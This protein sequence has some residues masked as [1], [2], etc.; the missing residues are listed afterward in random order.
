VQTLDDEP[1]LDVYLRRL[2]ISEPASSDELGRIAMQ[3][4][5]GLSR[6]GP[7]EHVRGITG[8]DLS[9]RSLTCM[10]E[11]PRGGLVWMMEAAGSSVL[12]ATDGA[13]QDSLA[14]L[15]GEPPVG[16]LVFDCIAR[17]GVLGESGIKD[18]IDRVASRAGEAPVA[19]FYTYGEIAR[20]RGIN[21]FHNQT[22]VVFSMA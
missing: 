9:D 19:G 14:A 4:P 1:A 7:E 20:A 22:I 2:A 8:C 15:D 13:C 16:M 6:P 18:E 10:A 11:V 5:F 3:H 12:D 17:K 21:G